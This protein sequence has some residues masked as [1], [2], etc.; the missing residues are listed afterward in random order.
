MI[1]K[2]TGVERQV[3]LLRLTSDSSGK[4]VVRDLSTS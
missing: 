1:G 3:S 2:E 4:S